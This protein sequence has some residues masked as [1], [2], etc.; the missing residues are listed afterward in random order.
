LRK[1]FDNYSGKYSKPG[2]PKAISIE[3]FISLFVD[4]GVLIIEQSIG[5][6]ELGAQYNMSMQ[7]QINE[8]EGD[9]HL[10]MQFDEFI[11]AICRVVEKVR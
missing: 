4:S 8:L 3:E 5:N 2:C 6:A 11:E 1:L 7:T 10:Q 9:R